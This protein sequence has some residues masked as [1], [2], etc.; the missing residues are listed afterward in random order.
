MAK[1]MTFGAHSTW[2]S[3]AAFTP[4]GQQLITASEDGTVR[5]TNAVDG[6]LVRSKRYAYQIYAPTRGPARGPGTLCNF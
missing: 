4:N 3:S 5:T 6:S 2:V 1:K